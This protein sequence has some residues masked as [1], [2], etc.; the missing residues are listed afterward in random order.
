MCLITTISIYLY[1]KDAVC[2]ATELTYQRMY[3]SVKEQ[4]LTFDAKIE[5]QFAILE[6]MTDS[7]TVQEISDKNQMT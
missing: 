6:T 3:D 2:R 5:G 1:R 4:C 7:I